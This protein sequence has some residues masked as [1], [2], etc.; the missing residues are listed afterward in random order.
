MIMIILMIYMIYA[1]VITNDFSTSFTSAKNSYRIKAKPSDSIF[2]NKNE[3]FLRDKCS[4]CCRV[5]MVSD[6]NF[7]KKQLFES[8]DE[9]QRFAMDMEFDDISGTRNAETNYEQTI[10]LRPLNMD[11]I[12]QQFE[13]YSYKMI[14]SFFIPHRVHDIRSGIKKG[15]KLI[16]WQ[17]KPPL[18]VSTN[19]QRFVYIH[20]YKSSYY[21]NMNEV[22]TNYQKHFYAPFYTTEPVCYEAVTHNYQ[23]WTG[24]KYLT[25][26]GENYQ[27]QI[28]AC[29]D[30]PKQF[31]TL[32]YV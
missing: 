14:N 10:L 21:N 11:N 3:L 26:L 27:I 25:V 17:K 5:V 24:N 7:N 23:R 8:N 20:P 9:D 22:Y 13:L 31:F 12:L 1:Q 30:N 19:N 28:N 29:S 6:Y 4:T 18:D 2:K 32:I 16:I 15:N